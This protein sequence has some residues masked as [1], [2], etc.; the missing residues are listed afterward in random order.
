MQHLDAT[1]VIAR[2]LSG[3]LNEGELILGVQVLHHTLCR[4]GALAAKQH[5]RAGDTHCPLDVTAG[6]GRHFVVSGDDREGE[7]F[8]AGDVD[9]AVDRPLDRSTA[10]V[11]RGLLSASYN[12][13][14]TMNGTVRPSGAV[15]W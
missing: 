7:A 9:G 12:S 2:G 8:A 10:G 3:L 13:S 11:M 5:N 4:L 15:A 1:L 14:D 6:S